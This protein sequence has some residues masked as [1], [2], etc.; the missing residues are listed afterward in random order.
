MHQKFK[1]MRKIS[2]KPFTN[3][4]RAFSN[5]GENYIFGI[6]TRKVGAK[7]FWNRFPDS[8][9]W[10]WVWWTFRHCHIRRFFAAPLKP[11]SWIIFETCLVVNRQIRRLKID[12]LELSRL[13]IRST[14]LFFSR[15]FNRAQQYTAQHMNKGSDTGWSRRALVSGPWIC[16]P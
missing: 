5:L 7:E 14:E 3:Y 2:I 10:S 11:L 12:R 13:T 8:S 16:K 15:D 4:Y 6:F 1:F 9:S